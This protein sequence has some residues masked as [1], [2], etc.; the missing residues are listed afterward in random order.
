[1]LKARMSD[2]FAKHESSLEIAF[3]VGGFIFDIWMLAAPDE[4]ISIIQ[5]ISYLFLIAVLI[6]FELLHRLVRWRPQ[7]MM[8]RIWTYRTFIMHFLLGSLLSVY[9]LFYIKSASIFSSFVFLLFIIGLL[10]ANELPVIKRANV[11]FKIGLYAICLF[12]FLSIAYPILFGFLGFVP[13][14]FSL[15]TTLGILYLQYKQLQ[16]AIPQEP[17]L[18]RAVMAPAGSVM[19][20]FFIFYFLGWIPPVPLSVKTQGVY[21]FIEK[22]DGNYLLSYQPEWPY[23]IRDSDKV[24]KALPGDKIYFFAQIYSPARI[25]DEVVIH[26]H[27]KN[28]KDDWELM[29]KI[30]LKIQGGRELGYRGYAFKSNYTPGEWKIAVKTSSGIEISRHYFTVENASDNSDTR[31]FSIIS[32]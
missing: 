11:S 21:H 13:F 25:S 2:F 7:G 31:V 20:L 3:F 15:V 23:F 18:F 22:K 24:F 6:H 29:D 28:K 32:K 30:P 14:M 16:R 5:Q 26:W 8:V 19:I 10:L 9:S 4:V 1:M 17:V 12:S 27:Q